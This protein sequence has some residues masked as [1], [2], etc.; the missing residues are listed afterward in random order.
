MVASR[1]V[2]GFTAIFRVVMW[3]F[4]ERFRCVF[5]TGLANFLTHIGGC[6]L[7]LLSG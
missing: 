5:V 3:I 6:Y 1:A 4:G 7:L 2:A